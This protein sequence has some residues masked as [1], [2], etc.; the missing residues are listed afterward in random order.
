MRK[1]ALVL[2]VGFGVTALAIPAAARAVTEETS[3]SAITY[4]T[5]FVNLQPGGA[6]DRTIEQYVID[7]INEAQPGTK[8]GFAVRDWTVQPIA[9]ALLNAHN[10]GVD[11]TGVID[12]GERNRAF[13]INLVN[14]LGGRVIF[15]GSPDY[16]FHSCISNVILPS[17]NP[18]RDHDPL[19]MHNKFWL[20]S[21]LPDGTKDV[22]LQTSQNWT[23][24][25]RSQFNDMVRING[26]TALYGGYWAYLD[27]MHAQ[28]RDDDYQ[29]HSSAGTG[30]KNTMYPMP[31][32]QGNIWSQDVIVDRLSEIDCSQGGS[33]TGT[34]LVQVGQAF[35]RRQRMAVADQLIALEKHGC[36]VQVVNSHGDAEIVAE[37]INAGID[38][39][40]LF[41]GAIRGGT[42]HTKYWLVDANRTVDGMRTKIV[43]AGSDNWRAD[44]QQT[45]DMLLR[46]VN[47]GVYDAYANHWAGM[48]TR[49]AY[50]R[51]Q[52][53]SALVDTEAPATAITASH[54]LGGAA[55][56]VAVRI[57]GSDGV[58][59]GGDE[60]DGA[61][62]ATG[63]SRLHVEMSGAQTGTWDFPRDEIGGDAPDYTVAITRALTVSAPGTT[64]VTAWGEDHK[65]NIGTPVSYTVINANEGKELRAAGAFA[66][67][68]GEQ[69]GIGKAQGAGKVE[70]GD[71]G[72]WTWAFTPT[73]DGSGAVVIQASDGHN[74]RDTQ[75]LYWNASNVAPTSSITG[76]P[77]E[78]KEGTQISLG[79][80][81]SDPSS[82]DT[83]AGFATSWSVTKNGDAYDSGSG[84]SFSFTPH[85]NGTYVVHFSAI[86]KDGG[87][88]TD[89]ETLNVANVAPSIESFEL[90]GV[91]GTAC[92]SGNT[93]TVS[94]TVSDPA[95][96]TDDPITGSI[97]WGDGSA[98]TPISG[99]IVS[100]S[101]SYGAGAFTLSVTVNDGDGRT[102][103]DGSAESGISH[104]YAMSAILAP[105]N[106][107]GTSIWR[108][109]ATIPVKVRILDCEGTPVAGLAP[110][111]ATQRRSGNTPV[112]PV[113]EGS[114]TGAADSDN[115]MRYD[116]DTGQYVYNLASGNLADGTA[117]YFVYAN[118]PHS[119]GVDASGTLTPGTSSQKFGLK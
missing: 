85:D 12:G 71:D 111:V 62:R 107:D 67:G 96:D 74:R 21:E 34:G 54:P 22:V 31:H 52:L 63:I 116:A 91:S 23:P 88:G 109:G 77:S 45:D 58:G 4:E 15:C 115:I 79:G 117:T 36:D 89:E 48:K 104:L 82:V 47:D 3:A 55:S 56:E 112:G 64:T 35:F 43:Y 83:A 84:A 73:D 25:Q 97:D 37:L 78:P 53:P 102:D 17:S 2:A 100:Q 24:T 80:V 18:N 65:G 50:T 94:F 33:A 42:T 40:P 90:G 26:D 14:R 20:F 5:R 32:H 28:A 98:D 103:S 72:T 6:E 110:A 29:P 81:V 10:R 44:E 75:E 46:I 16:E 1:I 61:S 76:V 69:L 59:N 101:H 51:T 49:S 60:E 39:Y 108:Y 38:Y 118:E 105:F 19:L 66:L 99:R 93:V 87:E 8:I 70:D 86:D 11:I 92:A 68:E 13:L 95:D 113:N 114:T 30:A 9:T 41:L 27:A 7:R 106:A 119:T 57:T